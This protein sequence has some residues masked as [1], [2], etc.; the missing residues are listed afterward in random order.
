MMTVI[1]VS[2]GRG[3]MP[4]SLARKLAHFIKLSEVEQQILQ[5]M[6]ARHRHVR[7]RSD[8]VSEGDRLT[9]LS[10]ITE[11]FACRYK[12][13]ANGRRQILAF[14]IPGDI[15]DLRALLTGKMDHGVVAVSNNQIAAIPRQSIFDAIE[16][17]PRVG[18]A[19]WRDT[20]LEAAI[21][22]QWIIDNGRRSSYQRI[23]HLICE[24]GARLEA[25]G[26]LHGSNYDLPM[27]QTHLADAMG[28]SLVHV[29]RTL[30][31]LRDHGLLTFREHEVTVVDWERLRA[32]AEFDPGYL[33]LSR[34]E[35]PL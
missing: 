26:R 8:I 29:N 10:L 15:C 11:G 18:V 23:A 16:K 24:I 30:K 1:G 2:F 34:A 33:Q 12:I 7:A 35:A 22:C 32:A 27:T 3:V 19:L 5:S 21:F 4:E 9:E 20:M 17:Y 14:L 6:P 28:L 25:I 13:L 31:Q